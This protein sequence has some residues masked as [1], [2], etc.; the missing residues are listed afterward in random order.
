MTDQNTITCGK[1]KTSKCQLLPVKRSF[2]FPATMIFNLIAV[3][4]TNYDS[5]LAS[6]RIKLKAFYL[7]YY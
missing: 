6:F 4:V 3:E 2:D 1:S 7:D 5:T